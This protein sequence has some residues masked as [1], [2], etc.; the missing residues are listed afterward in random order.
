LGPIS[1]FALRQE[2]FKRVHSGGDRP[3]PSGA[4]PRGGIA[5]SDQQWHQLEQLAAA[6]SSPGFA[7]SASQVARGLLVLSLKAVTA[8]L[9]QS[10]AGANDSP[11]VRELSATAA[12]ATER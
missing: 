2:L 4:T 3:E 1:L 5:V 6:I 7:P 10:G 8:Q 12:A 11:L 9:S